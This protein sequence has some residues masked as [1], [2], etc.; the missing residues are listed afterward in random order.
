M[1]GP[2]HWIAAFFCVVAP[3]FAI[4]VP[5]VRWLERGR[6]LGRPDG[7]IAAGFVSFLLGLMTA[8]SAIAL[9]AFM[10]MPQLATWFAGVI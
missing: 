4:S 9:L 2:E 1:I 8:L 7:V 5:T 10:V 6:Q 3:L